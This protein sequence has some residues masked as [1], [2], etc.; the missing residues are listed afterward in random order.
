[1]GS[2]FIFCIYIKNIKYINKKIFDF[3]NP[4]NSFDIQK[5]NLDESTI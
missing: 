3:S 5:N 1:M 2:E 4:N